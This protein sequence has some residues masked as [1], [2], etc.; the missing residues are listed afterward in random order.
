MEEGRQGDAAGVIGREQHQSR[1]VGYI[2]VGGA[3]IQRE[4]RLGISTLDR[5]DSP[6]DEIEN[7]Y[8]FMKG[9]RESFEVEALLAILLPSIDGMQEKRGTEIMT[10]CR[11]CLLFGSAAFTV[12]CRFRERISRKGICCRSIGKNPCA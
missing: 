7:G 3:G 10:H 2:L 8:R 4:H 9:F 12:A 11:Y 5:C 6:V 1:L